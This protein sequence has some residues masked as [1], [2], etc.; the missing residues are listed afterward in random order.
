VVQPRDAGC[1]SQASWIE[2][3]VDALLAAL[4]ELGMSASRAATRALIGERVALGVRD[5]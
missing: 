4:R 5:S 3:R 2:D 1:E